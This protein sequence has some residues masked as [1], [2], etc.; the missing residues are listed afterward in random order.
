MKSTIT[1]VVETQELPAK[2]RCDLQLAAECIIIQKCFTGE[3]WSS[4][5]LADEIVDMVLDCMSGKR[6]FPKR[7]ELKP[8]ASFAVKGCPSWGRDPELG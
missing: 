1:T 6:E 5:V 7:E 8:W 3:P 2:M 4:R